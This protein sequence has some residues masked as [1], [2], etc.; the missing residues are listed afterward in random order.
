[1]GQFSTILS[2][3]KISKTRPNSVSWEKTIFSSNRRSVVAVFRRQVSSH[4]PPHLPPLLSSSSS[5]TSTNS[6]ILFHFSN[7]IKRAEMKTLFSVEI[8]SIFGHY[9]F[10]ANTSINKC[11]ETTISFF[12]PLSLVLSS[13]FKVRA[14]FTIVFYCCN[15][16]RCHCKALLF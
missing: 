7:E 5:S 10:H 16:S 4:F 1:M 9:F 11:T 14:C 8:I 3:V 15:L 13:F 12:F 6:F 2:S